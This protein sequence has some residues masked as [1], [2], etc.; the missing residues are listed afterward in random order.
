VLC[1]IEDE[2]ELGIIQLGEIVILLV[3][4]VG[5]KL[6]ELLVCLLLQ[7]QHDEQLHMIE[8]IKYIHLI[9]LGLLM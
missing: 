5:I 3:V 2:K 1:Q 6:N 9:V 8:I 7:K 4:I